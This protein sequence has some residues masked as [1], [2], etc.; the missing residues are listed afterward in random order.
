MKATAAKHRGQP[1]GLPAV[2][3][4]IPGILYVR[5]MEAHMLIHS[6]YLV[7]NMAE[8]QAEEG[9]RGRVGT[10]GFNLPLIPSSRKNA[11]ANRAHI[12]T[13]CQCWC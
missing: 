6:M 13:G 8:R 4:T 1:K 2:K 10:V 9:R 11:Q 7:E 12:K 5:L 3:Q